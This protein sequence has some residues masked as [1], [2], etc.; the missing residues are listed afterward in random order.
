M[1]E[2]RTNKRWDGKT[3][4]VVK[5]IS[6]Q[7]LAQRGHRRVRTV[8]AKTGYVE[9]VTIPRAPWETEQEQAS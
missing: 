5:Q 7:E 2:R 8:D 6:A 3:T 9:M 1:K 4:V